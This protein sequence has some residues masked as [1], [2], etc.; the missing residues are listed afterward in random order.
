MRRIRVALLLGRGGSS[1][2]DKNIREVAGRPLLQWPA[3]AARNFGMDHYFVSSD[4]SKILSAAEDVGYRSIL[5]PGHLATDSAR[6]CDVIK[7][8]VDVITQELRLDSFDIL[9]QHA[10]SPL[11]SEDKIA[12]AMQMFFDDPQLTAVVPCYQVEDLHPYRL[13][14]IDQNGYLKNFISVP[15]GTSS[16]RQE[17]PPVYALNHD[18]WLLRSENFLHDSPGCQPPWECMGGK[19]APLF[20]EESRDVHTLEDLKKVDRE[21]RSRSLDD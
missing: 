4:D 9:M 13:K 1:L 16:N 2:P 21:L 3:I 14:S 15:D 18:F 17:L 8:A 12:K 20:S 7:H 11:Y 10:N 5:R 19:I 6:A